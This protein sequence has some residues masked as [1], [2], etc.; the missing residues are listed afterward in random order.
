MTAKTLREI[1]IEQKRDIKLDEL[2]EVLEYLEVF[3][4]LFETL[5][6]DVF[7]RTTLK[8]IYGERLHKLLGAINNSTEKGGESDA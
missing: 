3:N 2:P 1:L 5:K 7:K 4:E 6:E 8:E